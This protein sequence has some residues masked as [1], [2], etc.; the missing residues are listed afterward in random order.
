[1]KNTLHHVRVT[2]LVLCVL[3]SGCAATI[4]SEVTVF[5][6]WPADVPDKSFVFEQKKSLEG[7]LEYQSYQQLVRSELQRL[8]FTD[9]A[10]AK[11]AALRVAFDY[12]V[13]MRDVRVIQPV[14]VNPYG[15]GGGFYGPRFYRHGG[16][17]DPFYDPFWYTPPVVAYQQFDYQLYRRKLHIGIAQ[18]SNG[19][20]LY[21]V[22]VHS[23]G[24]IS[25]LASV[26]PYMV[27][28]AFVGFPGTNGV[29]RQV[30]L[31]I[32]D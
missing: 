16:F 15:Y 2:L 20:K 26:M 21:D 10:T 24:R 6:A 30:D 3:L 13:K 11:E 18:A 1:M 17:Y 23:E 19:K 25:A 4:R 28:S 32:K 22:T 12:D 7:D 31:P 8:G 5:Q 27:H 29:A 14:W 9:A